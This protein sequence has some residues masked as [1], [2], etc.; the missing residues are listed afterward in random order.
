MK[1]IY[2]LGL[3]F[4]GLLGSC[5]NED[6]VDDSISYPKGNYTIVAS[7]GELDSRAF[8]SNDEF[9]ICWQKEDKIGVYGIATQNA[10]F[11]LVPLAEGYS[12][13][14][15]FTGDLEGEDTPAYA[16]YPYS[17]NGTSAIVLPETYSITK[18]T[19]NDG[20][21][22]MIGKIDVN[23]K[24]L[25]FR[26]LCGIVK[27]KINNIPTSAVK[28]VLKAYDVD[29]NAKPIAGIASISEANTEGAALALVQESGKSEVSVTFTVPEGDG[30]K[31]RTFY[32]PV[33]TGKYGK[34]EATLYDESNTVLYANATGVVDIN[35]G[36]ALNMSDLDTDIWAVVEEGGEYTLTT[37]LT[38]DFIISATNVI[39]NLNGH[40]ITNKLGDTF[41]VNKGSK[42]TLNG[43]G[44]VDNV[45]DGKA[46]IYNNGTVVLNGGTY[47]RSK[48]AA[49]TPSSSGGNSFYN[50]LNHGTMTIQP[51][52][53]ISSTGA[54]SSLI[55]N[56]YYS[57]TS[58]NAR[59]GY[60]NG[61]N[62]PNPSL[63]INGGTFSGGINTIKN[64]DGANLTIV[65]GTFSNTTQATVQNNNVAEIRGGVF[66]PTA[67][68]SHAVETKAYA[69]DYNKGQT[70]ISGGT[71]MG[72]LYL[73]NGESAH[74]ASFNI[75]GGTFSDPFALAYLGDNAD[76]TVKL[77]TDTELVKSM[78]V[79]KGTATID[80][81]NHALTANSS[82]TVKINNKDEA[83]VAV[84]VKDGAKAM[85]KNGKIGDSSNK[86]SYGVFAFGKAN[87]TLDNVSFSEMV[88]YAYNGAGE[89]AA[90]NCTFKGWLSGWH[91]GGT[92]TGCTFT[93]GKAWYPAAICYGS[94][95]FTNCKF[96]KNDV[97]ADVY[98]DGG[99]PD[100]DGYYRCSYVVAQCNPSNSIGFTSCKFI[101][102]NNAET[103]GITKDNHPFHACG[104]GNGTTA[105]Y[106]VTVDGAV[107]TSQ[108]SDKNKTSNG[109]K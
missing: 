81:N 93:I 80:L 56:G 72:E 19:A 79:E 2:L 44:T 33:P 104:W 10:L 46:C 27:I 32:I 102:E 3:L 95:T 61:T 83:V 89:L 97:D 64:D 96:L 51:G 85:V 73:Y 53:T 1:K 49:N 36:T 8:V 57:Y 92:F 94:T 101:D 69:T 59:N 107:V 38:G 55:D 105:D 18:G 78:I 16:Y 70:T 76:V 6:I 34:L 5:S 26:H 50:I 98:D 109:N 84:A 82:A 12:G 9:N 13:L 4:V 48:E 71:F 75:T 87:V 68:A 47:T 21:G 63:I 86:L 14:G 65:D 66:N 37:D 60:V 20:I 88:I 41:T 22:P 42:L 39:I 29:G 100:E 74:T 35:K 99:A 91:H 7:M 58:E 108:C 31:Y 17:E 15:T 52:V 103:G 45:S 11:E 30:M 106:N 40:K 90:T 43:E 62:Q 28:F 67:S 23:T 54:F 25:H 24:K 77:N